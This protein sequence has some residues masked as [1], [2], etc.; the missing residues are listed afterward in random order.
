MPVEAASSFWPLVDSVMRIDTVAMARYLSLGSSGQL[1]LLV[2]LVA[3]ISEAVGNSVVLFINRVALVRF[4]LTLLVS[5]LILAF[6]YFFWTL[7]V[8]LIARFGFGNELSFGLVARL[9]GF[10]FAPRVF[11]FLEFLPVLGRPLAVL[12]Q[13][14]SLLAV[15][16]SA[17]AVLG[18]QPW[19]ALLSVALGALMVLT[20]QQTVGRPLLRLG[21]WALGRAAGVPL[22]LD[23]SGLRRLVRAGRNRRPG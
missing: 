20:L 14:Y 6:T 1:A 5:S 10:G 7:T 4:V 8:F 9:V 11:G 15:L 3:G 22:V 18:L 23:R 2:V 21:H 13:L 16:L 12:L 17:V 19:E